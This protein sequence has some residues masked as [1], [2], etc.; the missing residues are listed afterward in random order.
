MRFFWSQILLDCYEIPSCLPTSSPF[1]PSFLPSICPSF[2]LPCSALWPCRLPGRVTREAE[3]KPSFLGSRLLTAS[4]SPPP[5]ARGCPPH[6][7]R[8]QVA[9]TVHLGEALTRHRLLSQWSPPAPEDGHSSP[10]LRTFPG[11][12]H[13]SFS[14]SEPLLPATWSPCPPPGQPGRGPAQSCFPVSSQSSP[15]H[16]AESPVQ[17]SPVPRGAATEDS[18]WFIRVPCVNAARSQGRASLASRSRR[19]LLVR[20]TT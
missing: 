13:L 3:P 9:V 14:P 1:L 4:T 15:Q 8:S 6:P 2:V 12:L 7:A 10:D 5:P 20:G 18:V 19:L 11:G 17:P 16:P